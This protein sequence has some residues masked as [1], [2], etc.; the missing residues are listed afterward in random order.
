MTM[1]L[2]IS[3]H[4]K[5]FLKL[6][7]IRHAFEPES[8]LN[9]TELNVL[10][11]LECR[12]YNNN[13]DTKMFDSKISKILNI[14][15]RT[16]QRAMLKLEKM[17]FITRI[18]E[19]FFDSRRCKTHR[20]GFYSDRVIRCN[21]I[22][23]VYRCRPKTKEELGWKRD[24]RP[25]IKTEQFN[26]NQIWKGRLLE[27][28]TFGDSNRWPGTIELYKMGSFSMQMYS[29]YNLLES[30]LNNNEKQAMEILGY[31]KRRQYESISSEQT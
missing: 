1:Q 23:L 7:F 6:S 17:G 20:N 26:M 15:I 2:S 14:S 30:Q 12:S 11:I 27:E 22:F 19:H 24:I 13:G 28:E 5:S 18:T 8:K 29:K 25:K 4:Y 9:N 16:V 21:R 3:K 10:H 31:P